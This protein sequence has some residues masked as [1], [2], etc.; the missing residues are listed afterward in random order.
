MHIIHIIFVSSLFIIYIPYYIYIYLEPHDYIIC[1]SNNYTIESS[2]NIINNLTIT[3]KNTFD[4]YYYNNTNTNI[5]INKVCYNTY[6]LNIKLYLWLM[7]IS[8]IFLKFTVLYI[9]YYKKFLK[10]YNYSISLFII[11][12]ILKN[13]FYI[14]S[15]LIQKISLNKILMISVI[16]EDIYTMFNYLCLFWFIFNVSIIHNNLKYYI[17]HGYYT[18]THCYTYILIYISFVTCITLWIGNYINLTYIDTHDSK[19]EYNKYLYN[20]D[21]NIKNIISKYIT[22]FIYILIICH[23]FIISYIFTIFKNNDYKYDYKCRYNIL[24]IKKNNILFLLFV[25]CKC[26][27]IISWSTQNDIMY[28]LSFVDILQGVIVC[29]IIFCLIIKLNNL[30]IEINNSGYKNNNPISY[31][32]CSCIDDTCADNCIDSIG[33][34]CNCFHSLLHKSCVSNDN[35]V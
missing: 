12:L 4:K 33:T 17:T 29:S 16:I 6:N 19:I 18:S 10:K 2:K 15:L 9:N 20:Y 31:L 13:I 25:F 7:P 34:C 32:R 24:I 3:D 27:E 28:Y 1:I 11:F 14:L 23:M 8:I 35:N 5:D 26:I 21:L 22:Y 30:N